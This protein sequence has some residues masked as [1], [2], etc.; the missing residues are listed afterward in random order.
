MAAVFACGPGAVL[1]HASAVVLWGLLRPIAGPVDVSVPS[2]AGRRQRPGIR[3]HRCPS[4]MAAMRGTS[5]PVTPV[6]RHLGIPVTTVSRTLADIRGA[7]PARLERRARRQAEVLGL[8]LGGAGSDRTR[9]DLEGAFLR[10]CRRHRL[11]APEV[12]AEVAGL[13]V[14]FLWRSA[15]LVVETDSYAYHR[16][17]VAFEDDRARDLALRELGFDVIRVAD[18]QLDEE[19]RRVAAFLADALHLRLRAP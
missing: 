14:D 9:S 5:D 1:S 6:T 2:T 3:L 7:L 19:S 12:N 10:L 11:P 18:R 4:L 16:G 13:T 17:R 15:G 8:P